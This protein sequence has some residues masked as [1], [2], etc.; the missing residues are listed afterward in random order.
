[1]L[2]ICEKTRVVSKGFFITNFDQMHN[3]VCSYMASLIMTQAMCDRLAFLRILGT[4]RKHT[5]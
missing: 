5:A 1:M 3:R 2:L 4:F